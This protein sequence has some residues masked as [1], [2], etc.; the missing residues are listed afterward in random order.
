MTY[1][2]SVSIVMNTLRGKISMSMRIVLI[3]L[4]MMIMGCAKN[5]HPDHIKGISCPE[6]GHGK[7]PFG[8]DD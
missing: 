3:T 5:P 1:L 8:C 7:C 2:G 6:Y 4:T